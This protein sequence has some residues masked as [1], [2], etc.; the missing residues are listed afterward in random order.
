VVSPV[1]ANIYLHNVLDPW[2]AEDFAARCRG[3]ANLIR[4]AD[5]FVSCF[6]FQADA[7]AFHRALAERLAAY[8]L[9]VAPEK[10]AIRRFGSDAARSCHRDRLK[11]PKPFQV[12]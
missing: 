8:D 1:L 6:Q 9:E 3:P 5:D 2:F 7:E 4:Y 12:P 11:R 10:T